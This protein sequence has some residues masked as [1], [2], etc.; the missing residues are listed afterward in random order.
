MFDFVRLQ[1]LG[2]IFLRLW[3]RSTLA[4]LT[5]KVCH[6][7][8]F[9]SHASPETMVREPINVSDYARLLL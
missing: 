8:G 3:L 7:R 5:Y 6:F 1:F 9:V 2:E 4:Q